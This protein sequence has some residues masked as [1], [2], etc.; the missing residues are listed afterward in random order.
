MRRRWLIAV[1]LL[2]IVAAA[3]L[4]GME[5]RQRIST[6]AVER[7]VA[8]LMTDSSVRCYNHSRNGSTWACAVGRPPDPECKVV[9]VS[10]FGSVS[11]ESQ[12]RECHYP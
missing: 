9:H 12:P 7:N 11:I 3:A 8:H 5:R 6:A 2:A 4:W 1:C 10:P